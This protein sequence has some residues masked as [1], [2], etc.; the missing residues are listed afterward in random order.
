MTHESEDPARRRPG[1]GV[2]AGWSGVVAAFVSVGV[3]ELAAA[4]VAPRAAPL[5]AI[6]DVVIAWVP[7]PLKRLAIDWFGTADKP[8]LQ[9]GIVVLLAALSFGIGR[10]AAT[11]PW[12]GVAAVAALAVAG[13]AAAVSRAD[14]SAVSVVPAVVGGVAGGAVLWWLSRWAVVVA[15]EPPDGVGRRRFLTTAVALAAGAAVTGFVSRWWSQRAVVEAARAAVVLP[16]PADPALELPAGHRLDVPGVTPWRTP[17]RDFYRIDTALTVPAVD[18]AEYRLRI[19]GRVAAPLELTYRELLDL[20]LIERDI[21]LCCVSNEV[22]GGLIG[23]ARWLGVRLADLLAEVRPDP[24]ADQLVGRSIDGFT[25]GAPTS[26]CRDG[27]DAMLAVGMNG[28]P[29]PAV[30]GFP[31]RMVVPGLYGYVSATKWLT[32]LELTSFDDYDAYWIP[33]GW[34]A[35]A[36]IKTQ[37]RIDTPRGTATAGEVAVAGVAWAQHRGIG[38]VEVRVD[39]GDWRPAELSAVASTDT[40]RQWVW[41]WRATP[42]RHRLTVRATDNSGETQTE[43]IAPPA[44]D[45]ATGLHSVTVQV[46]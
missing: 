5:A 22:G 17:I 1:G 37:S 13:A 23:N 2:R 35:T 16:P 12:W 44:P 29:L 8:V 25:A 14:A 46:D 40:W 30:H 26:V 32:E 11:R 33:R 24:G 27:R 34:S 19:H 18:P 3:G 9:L 43:E 38:A 21:T 6:G 20:P 41:R 36:P 42:G 15:A 10:L 7:E 39:D 28:E 45:G 31:V 4:V